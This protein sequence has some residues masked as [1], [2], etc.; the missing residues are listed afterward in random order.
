MLSR[1]RWAALNKRHQMFEVLSSAAL[2]FQQKLAK[3]STEISHMVSGPSCLKKNDTGGG[4]W[5]IDRGAFPPCYRSFRPPAGFADKREHGA[6]GGV[7]VDIGSVGSQARINPAGF[8]NET[9]L[10]IY[11][12]R[13]NST[14]KLTGHRGVVE[15]ACAWLDGNVVSLSSYSL[16]DGKTTK[17]N[18]DWPEGITTEVNHQIS[19]YVVVSNGIVAF[20][21]S[22]NIAISPIN[23]TNYVKPRIISDF[24]RFVFSGMSWLR[25]NPD[26][27]EFLF[28]GKPKG[29]NFSLLFKFNPNTQV[30]TKLNN[31]H[32]YNGQW[33]GHGHGFAYV[34]NRSNSFSLVLHTDYSTNQIDL[35]TNGSVVSYTADPSGKALYAIAATNMEPQGVWRY[36]IPTQ[37]L[38]RVVAGSEVPLKLAEIIIPEQKIVVSEKLLIPYYVFAPPISKEPTPKKHPLIL[39]LPAPTWQVQ[40]VYENKGQFYANIGFYYVGVNYRGCDGYGVNYASHRGSSKAY[41]D[42]LAVLRDLS[43]N[44][45]ID[46]NNVFLYSNSGGGEVESQ[47]IEH[48]PTFWR[49]AVFD[50]AGVSVFD[51]ETTLSRLPAFFLIGGDQ[52]PEL[53]IE[54]YFHVWAKENGVESSLLVEK[55][56]GHLNWKTSEL[57]EEQRQVCEFFINHLK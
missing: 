57:K 39:Y 53:P 49:G 48:Q 36:D 28:C 38:R 22:N 14:M 5:L 16:S 23:S 56:C 10:Y 13:S 40:R 8:K 32:T 9:L 41:L 43:N 7:S 27:D 44:P 3:V 55:N 37:T 2:A 52:D 30:I 25:Y 24:S 47:L 12:S 45:L 54:K 29:A 18:V 20:F 31:E 1:L 15:G 33:L 6:K 17:Y 4:V 50:H 51:S 35:F 46:T 19:D 42:V 26:S 11:D 34:A 21:F